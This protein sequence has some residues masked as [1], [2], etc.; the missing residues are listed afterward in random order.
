MPGHR[1]VTRRLWPALA[2]ATAAR[3][4]W[5]VRDRVPGGP[6]RWERTNHRGDSVSML[7]GPAWAV[8]AAAGLLLAPLPARA[9]SGLLL[10]TVGAAVFGAVDDLVES[11][12]TKGLRG[13]LG[14]LAA[15]RLT[16]G[17]LKVVGIGATG[18]AVAALLTPHRDRGVVGWGREVAVAGG[19]IAGAANLMNLL[20][21]RPGR[22][23]K[24]VAL[25]VPALLADDAG[26][27]A[28]AAA[29]GASAAL[30][31][32]DLREEA[33]LG[34]CGANSVGALLGTAV[35]L[36]TGERGRSGRRVR[37]AV[38]AGIVVLTLV[39]ERVSFTRVIEATPGLRELD[40]LGRRPAPAPASGRDAT[41]SEREGAG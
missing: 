16:T 23:L 8:G 29:L 25:H 32:P 6:G 9:R 35:V 12:S 28:V 13:H 26:G 21:L 17:G 3:A 19:V 2:A 22:V 10:A 27:T 4:C 15:G 37:G 39:S 5:Q 20:D 34:D 14:E 38:L 1:T 18:A 11:G 36:A 7:E 33:M 24:L 31:A 30:A 41:A 40:A